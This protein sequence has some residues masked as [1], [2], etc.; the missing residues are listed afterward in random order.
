MRRPLDSKTVS[1][2]DPPD[3]KQSVDNTWVSIFC[4]WQSGQLWRTWIIYPEGSEGIG[5]WRVIFRDHGP[6][7]P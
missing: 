4:G 7:K 2:N 5:G 3:S 6:R 1:D